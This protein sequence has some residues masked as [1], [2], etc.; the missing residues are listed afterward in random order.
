MDSYEDRAKQFNFA[1]KDA[2]QEALRQPETIVLDVRNLEEIAAD[3]KLDRA[4]QTGCTPDDCADLRANP[5]KFVSNQSATVVI[6]CRSGRR[7]ATARS[8]LEQMGHTGPILN[9]GG[10]DDIKDLEA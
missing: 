10:Y 1:S 8:I 2:V 6:Y 3:G 5:T 4:V 7:A 9:A